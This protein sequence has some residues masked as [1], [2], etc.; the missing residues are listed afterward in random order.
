MICK[1]NSKWVE[2]VRGKLTFKFSRTAYSTRDT[3]LYQF[4][5]TSIREYYLVLTGPRMCLHTWELPCKHLPQH[6]QPHFPFLITPSP[7]ILSSAEHLHLPTPRKSSL[8]EVNSITI[9]SQLT[10]D[11][12]QI[13]RLLLMQ[14]QAERSVLSRTSSHSF[15]WQ[16]FAK[17]KLSPALALTHKIFSENWGKFQ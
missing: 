10:H 5:P 16:G 6:R 9:I 15:S 13:A 4:I 8:N 12:T 17:A 2:K 1:Q 11:A 3:T 7:K 14:Q